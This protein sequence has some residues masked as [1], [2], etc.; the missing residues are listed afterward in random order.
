[1]HEPVMSPDW[2]NVSKLNGRP[3]IMP[4]APAAMAVASYLAVGAAD[5]LQEARAR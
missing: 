3:S 2:T 5:V 1:M 4:S